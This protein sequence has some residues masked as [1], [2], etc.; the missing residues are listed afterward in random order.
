MGEKGRP[1]L[2]LEQYLHPLI[3]L[4]SK[5]LCEMETFPLSRWTHGKGTG[6]GQKARSTDPISCGLPQSPLRISPSLQPR[7]L[8]V[9]SGSVCVFG[10]GTHSVTGIQSLLCPQLLLGDFNQVILHW[11][12]GPVMSELCILQT[13]KQRPVR[14]ECRR[15]Q[16]EGWGSKGSH[17]F[18]KLC[19]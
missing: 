11:E 12:T 19:L 8:Q 2:M 14:R 7:I 17:G 3:H 10:V 18:A 5:H 15:L 9:G 13:G 1:F 6:D 4:I 16:V